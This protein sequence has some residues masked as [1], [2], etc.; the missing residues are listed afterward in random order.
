MRY[1]KVTPEILGKLKKIVGENS[2]ITDPFDVEPYSHDETTGLKSFPEVVVKPKAKEEVVKLLSLSNQEGVPLTPRGG[3]TGVVGGAIPIFGGILL[4]L[5]KMNKI[6]EID[7]ANSMTVV[8]P[9]VI[10]GNLQREL[11][12]YELF[13]PVNPASLDSCTIGGN[14]ANSS[15]GANAV[16]YGGTKNYVCGLEAVLPSGEVIRAGGKLVKN[17]TDYRTIQFLLGSEGTLAVITEITLRVVPSPSVKVDLIVPLSEIT[18]ITEIVKRIMAKKIIPTSI[19]YLDSETVRITKN[20]LKDAPSL[21]EAPHY[22]LIEVD[23]DKKE[24]VDKDYQIIGEICLDR[25]ADDVLVVEDSGPQ[26]KIWKFRQ[27]VRD[28]LVS[29]SPIMVEEDIVVPRSRIASFLQEVRGVL[30]KWSL[31]AGIFGH[32]GDGNVHINILKGEM[33]D[34]K[35]KMSTSRAVEDLFN[36]A[37]SLGGKISG[38]HGIGIVK[39]SYLSL[40]MDEAQLNLMRK[41]KRVFDPKNV[42]NP[43]KIFD[44]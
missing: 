26:E 37:I 32:L 31:S 8:Q 40:V 39:K 42:L 11:K 13:Y 22:L 41:I 1:A 12:N 2:V 7:S 44:M 33:E 35:W 15:S 5:E 29:F 43:G 14:V 38:E 27:S 3:G 36:I 16:K 19:E 6:L 24:E 20:Y 23:G 34:E 18:S 4:S 28:A 9:G 30:K 10:N 17:V 25:G 21:P